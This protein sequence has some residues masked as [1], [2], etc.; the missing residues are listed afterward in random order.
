MDG[1][2]QSK[3]WLKVV[4]DNQQSTGQVKP[5]RTGQNCTKPI[6][7]A[8]PRAV[9][10]RATVSEVLKITKNFLKIILSDFKALTKLDFNKSETLI[11]SPSLRAAVDGDKENVG[12]LK[13]TQG[14]RWS[15]SYSF[16][17]GTINWFI[18]LL[19]TFDTSDLQAEQW[20][21]KMNG[22]AHAEVLE[23]E[24][25]A[26]PERKL[27]AKLG[28]GKRKASKNQD[29]T[30]PSDRDLIEEDDGAE[31]LDSRSS[32]FSRKRAVPPTSQLQV[33][34]KLK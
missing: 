33:K 31:D 20:I 34:K 8:P 24:P 14:T 15:H 1:Q 12:E 4:N 6:F 11:A 28:A 26:R 13:T 32:A 30:T 7:E 17:S 21:N 22:P 25:E 10:E 16:F 27:S 23:V 9:A 29:S 19:L 18:G 2:R 3:F 5:V